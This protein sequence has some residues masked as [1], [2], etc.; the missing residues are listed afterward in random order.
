MSSRRLSVFWSG[1]AVSQIGTAAWKLALP[2][3]VFLTTRSV[4]LLA[5]SV[6]I[7]LLPELFMGPVAGAL[8]DR[9]P[10]LP[11]VVVVDVIRAAG[12]TIAGL[13]W[14]AHPTPVVLFGAGLVDGLLQLLYM[15]CRTAVLREIADTGVD[16]K[17]LLGTDR[18]IRSVADVTGTLTGGVLAFGFSSAVVL[19]GNGLSYA[20]SALTATALLHRLARV[21][22]PPRRHNIWRFAAEGVV[23]A[24]RS[25]LVSDA[26]V[27]QFALNLLMPVLTMGALLVATERGLTSGWLGAM[28][29]GV[30]LGALAASSTFIRNRIPAAGA[31][32]RRSWLVNAAFAVVLLMALLLPM[33]FVLPLFAVAGGV[34][35]FLLLD[36]QLQWQSIVATDV[37]GRVAS[38][39]NIVARL[40]AAVGILSVSAAY[41]AV[42]SIVVLAVPAGMVFVASLARAA[43]TRDPRPAVPAPPATELAGVSARSDDRATRTRGAD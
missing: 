38:L 27:R 5:L 15:A 26:M 19:I 30:S 12:F 39:G 24:R 35:A 7:W 14:L 42:P 23:Q 1:Y 37:V 25:T 41:A 32:P 29:A 13:L 11:T 8:A 36:L 34:M 17:K 43:R 40:G 22:A 3:T 31:R 18:A 4:W 10:R 28:W 6:F 20:L 16:L 21:S 2:W 33:P 9:L